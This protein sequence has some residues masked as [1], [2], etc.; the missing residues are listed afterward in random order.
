MSK[1]FNQI[2]VPQEVHLRRMYVHD[3]LDKLDIYIQYAIN[4]G[5]IRV[6]VIH[7]KGTGVLRLAVHEFLSKHSQVEKYY[8]AP[9]N[10]GGGGVT[11]AELHPTYNCAPDF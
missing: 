9:P 5:H 4:A 11:I 10:E 8:G 7:G 3:A 6:R 2:S 1:L